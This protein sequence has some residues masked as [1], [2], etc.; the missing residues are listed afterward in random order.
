M[1]NF[2]VRYAFGFLVCLYALAIITLHALHR[3]PCPGA[4][5]LSQL[6]GEPVTTLEGRIV[7]FP[8][9]RWG[10][11]RFVLEGYD[12]AK[13]Q[14]HGRVLVT[15]GYPGWELGP[16]DRL[17]LR[18]WLHSMR[19]PSA[20]RP[21]DEKGYWGLQGVFA[22]L[23][24]WSRDGMEIITPA[25]RWSLLHHAW[26]FRQ[27]FAD[28]WNRSLPEDQA[29]LLEGIT[30]GARGTL[31]KDLKEACI[32]AGVYHMVVVSGQKIAWLV[33]L[34]MGILGLCRVPRR[35]TLWVC[36]PVLIFYSAMVGG[37][38]PVVRASVMACTALAVIAMGRDI[39]RYYALFLAA[40]WILLRDPAA[41]LGASFQLSFA[42]TACLIYL[43]S[44][45]VNVKKP[46][47]RWQRWFW[48]AGLMGLAVNLGV[49]PLLIYYF[50]QLSVAG[51]LA[52]WTLFP[53]SG[54]VMAFGLAVGCWG[55]LAPA[56][57]PFW[58][59]RIA[60]ILAAMMLRAVRTVSGWSWAAIP[61]RPL[62]AEAT[63]VYYT[64]L[65]GILFLVRRRS[66][67]AQ[68]PSPL[69]ARRYRLPP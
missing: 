4:H 52:N 13:P 65:F 60:G 18:G 49:W 53:F 57:V 34:G 37:D 40:A 16:G 66:I 14:F 7:D 46:A 56:T 21:F 36:A 19:P 20:K 8:S 27:Q 9:M 59:I 6:L 39:P 33:G 38:P 50:H 28:F 25:S 1:W 58:V 15:L 69:S 63:F 61:L 30:L 64:C 68:F 17:R 45:L 48:Q 44:I 24:G 35:W 55:A 42:A 54:I 43:G 12:V 47:R 23:K 32:R 5:D 62:S 11:T 31:P 3:F 41:V 2:M 26:L 67:H 29:Q 51:L 22:Q 10:Q